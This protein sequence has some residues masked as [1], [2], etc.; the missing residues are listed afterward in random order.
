MPPKK[1]TKNGG[2][3]KPTAKK[4]SKSRAPKQEAM[5]IDDGQ[6]PDLR[7][8]GEE[9]LDARQAKREADADV[10]KA[11]QAMLD[12]MAKKKV[13]EFVL[14]GIRFVPVEKGTTLRTQQPRKP[15]K[16]KRGPMT[17]EDAFGPDED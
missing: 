16:S 5:D 1:Q 4:A 11:R 7:A 13:D 10:K 12:L 15:K 2:G 9:F 14:D 8:C 17:L 6:D 3:K